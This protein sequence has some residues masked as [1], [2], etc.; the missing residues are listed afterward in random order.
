MA[1]K[2][3]DREDL[4]AEAVTLQPRI[5]FVIGSNPRQYVAGRRADGRWSL[6]CDGDPVYHFDPY[7]RL[8]RAFVDQCLYRSEG[9]TLARLTRQTNEAETVL[10]R[11]D[12]TPAELAAFREQ[13]RESLLQISSALD[14]GQLVI[15]RCI[16]PEADYLPELRGAISEVLRSGG[17]LSPAIAHR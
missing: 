8:R 1:R 5:E 15:H 13:L 2:S 14:Q 6:F 4:M 17:A 11:H 12:L 10:L 7:H 16:P 9:A 3:A